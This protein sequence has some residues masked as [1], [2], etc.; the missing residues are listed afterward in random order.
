ML[1]DIPWLSFHNFG[2]IRALNTVWT[3]GKL[4]LLRLILAC[5]YDK[6]VVVDVDVWGSIDI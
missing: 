1:I 3:T 5:F 4:P 2:L 6:T